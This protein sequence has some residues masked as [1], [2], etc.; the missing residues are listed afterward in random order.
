MTPEVVES[1]SKLCSVC[2]EDIDYYAYGSCN[3]PTCTKCVL[4]LR[5][6]GSADEP[7][8]SKCPTCRQNINRVVIMRK[9][10]PFDRID[11]SVLR[12]DSRFD[13]MFPDVNIE[14]YYSNMLKSVC[15]ICGEEKKSLSAL[16]RHTTAE[17][18][19]SYCDLCIRYAR[20]LPCEFTL[21]KPADLIKHRS[22]DKTKKKGH[23]LCDFCQERFYEMEDLIHHIRDLHFLCDLCMA[24][25]KFVVFREQCELLDHYG[26]SHH[27]CTECRAQQRISCFATADRLGLHRFQ[28]HPN[29]V[30]NDPNPWLPISIRHVTTADSAFRRRDQMHPDVNSVGGVLDTTD[31]RLISQDN[32]NISYRRPNPSEWTG[33]DFPSLQSTRPVVFNSQAATNESGSPQTAVQRLRESAASLTE[34]EGSDTSSM[35]NTRSIGGTSWLSRVASVNLTNKNRLTSEDFPSL[36]QSPQSS[37]SNPLTWVNKNNTSQLPCNPQVTSSIAVSLSSFPTLAS[38]TRNS[39]NIPSSSWPRKDNSVSEEPLK[40]STPSFQTPTSCDFP[41]LPVN[42]SN[43]P[44]TTTNVIAHKSSVLENKTKTSKT[45]SNDTKEQTVT[46]AE[47]HTSKKSEA[48]KNT[49]RRN[50]GPDDAI[51]MTLRDDSNI[52]MERPQFTHIRTVVVAPDSNRSLHS[53]YG[54]PSSVNDFPSLSVR[55]NEEVDK[56]QKQNISRKEKSKEKINRKSLNHSEENCPPARVNNNIKPEISMLIQL[57]KSVQFND[58]MDIECLLYAKAEY[59][60]PPDVESR[61]L[62][63]IRTVETDL[64]DKNGRTA[65]SRFADLSRRYRYKEINATAYLEG[66]VGLLGVGKAN[67]SDGDKDENVPFWI[68]P[69]I[70]L[71][72]DIGLQRALLRALQA[73]GSPR[74]P[75]D[76]QEA[77]V[78]CGM[79][80]KRNK[81]PIFTPP[82]WAK[83]VLKRLQACQEC[84]QVCLRDDLPTHVEGAHSAKQ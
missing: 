44:K 17:H 48:K 10:V 60:P 83:K 70:S 11:V 84:G 62:E 19:L 74:I 13:F 80:V 77:L 1:V 3:H 34:R 37:T 6:F 21:M 38:S 32:S 67:P 51:G 43:H 76:M 73:Q 78:K 42:S 16:N 55:A 4:K 7:E 35:Q 65:F 15:P 52:Y 41:A 53:S 45:S 71:L 58:S 68:A 30:A 69:M 31:G 25:G 26:D 12:H 23:P 57:I 28:E 66:L 64:F 81:T 36:T 49:R 2:H 29:E 20:L 61:N 54:L 9:F 33:E 56:L 47:L 50:N 79:H 27:L 75:V 18:H 82:S 46:R 39:A 40:L 63:L 5:K 8:F 72:P 59:F 24:T 14:H 22:W